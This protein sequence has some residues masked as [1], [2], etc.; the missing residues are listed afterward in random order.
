[1]KTVTE[2]I[3]V[4]LEAETGMENIT[5]EVQKA[6][7]DSGLNNGIATVFIIGATGAVSTIEFEPGLLKDMPRALENIAP[8]DI[9]YEHHLTWGCDNGRSHVKS[10][11][12]GP[13]ITVPF[14]DGKL[15]LGT[16]QQIVAMNFD[17][18]ARSREIVIQILGE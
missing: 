11:L 9:P 10:T 13:S 6:V 2:R 16:W 3:S 14:T 1:M 17:T 12:L 4:G 8:S 7:G 15:T 5:A 18:K